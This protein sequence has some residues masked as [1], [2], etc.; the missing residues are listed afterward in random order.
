MAW[1]FTVWINCF[2]D[3]KNFANSWP[4]ASNFKIFSRSLEQF[5]LTVGQ[6]NF[7]IKI[8]LFFS[9]KNVCSAFHCGIGVQWGVKVI[10]CLEENRKVK[11]WKDKRISR[12]I[13]RSPGTLINSKTMQ[14]NGIK[15][16]YSLSKWSKYPN[17]I[18]EKTKYLELSDS[19]WI[20]RDLAKFS[21]TLHENRIFSHLCFYVKI[22]NIICIFFRKMT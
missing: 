1:P 6:N 2:I 22:Y 20:L 16:L 10:F 11:S 7:G 9:W 18:R 4:S 21:W 19:I 3:L 14:L 13:L 15:H 17:S 5:F 12:K 8:P